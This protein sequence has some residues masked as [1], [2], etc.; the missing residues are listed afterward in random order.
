MQVDSAHSE[1]NFRSSKHV[2]TTEDKAYYLATFMQRRD[3]IHA[4][5]SIEDD[6]F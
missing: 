6:L 3:T 2:H 4:C 5:Y 1:P